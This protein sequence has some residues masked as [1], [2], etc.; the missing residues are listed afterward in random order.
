VPDVVSPSGTL[1]QLD[2]FG[3]HLLASSVRSASVAFNHGSEVLDVPRN[4]TMT[5]PT[6][7]PEQITPDL[8][9][10][11]MRS[12]ADRSA[13][14]D[15][16]QITRDLLQAYLDVGDLATKLAEI[17]RHADAQTA[18]CLRRASLGL[19]ECQGW[20]EDARHARGQHLRPPTS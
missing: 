2:K 14:P 3:L 1:T 5:T 7:D 16:D 6:P 4:L 10:M 19:L 11:G 13:V 9:Q 17:A 15:A 8:L 18:A 12:T 20:L